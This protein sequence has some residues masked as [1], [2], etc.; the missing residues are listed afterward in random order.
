MSE[1]IK[2]IEVERFRRQ[3]K[4]YDTI[5]V[6]VPR[7]TA[8]WDVHILLESERRNR[9][10]YEFFWLMTGKVL[11]YEVPRLIVD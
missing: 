8:D 4:Y 11:K 3:G 10:D 6:E 5:E 2:K 7:L 1:S 9:K